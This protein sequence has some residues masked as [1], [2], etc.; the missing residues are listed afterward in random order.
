MGILTRKD[1]SA[2]ITDLE[3]FTLEV[4][5]CPLKATTH[6]IKTLFSEYQE[7]VA[8]KVA[9]AKKHLSDPKQR[10]R[11]ELKKF[12][13]H[14]PAHE[15]ILANIIKDKR[16]SCWVWPG[17]GTHGH[18]TIMGD[19][20]KQTFVH[21]VMYEH[22]NRRKLKLNEVVR[23][24]C[25]NGFCCN[26]RHLI[27]GTQKENTIDTSLRGRGG[28]QRLSYSTAKRVLIR[29]LKGESSRKLAK[30]FG[31]GEAHVR[32]LG[33]R[34]FK[35]LNDDPDVSK[36]PRKFGQLRNSKLTP[37]DVTDIRK[38]LKNRESQ[39]SI[40]KYYGVDVSLISGINTGRA[41]KSNDKPKSDE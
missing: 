6:I 15:R 37:E 26:P 30:E 17:S 25:D 20:K 38:R 41:W 13:H 14:T 27:V 3:V 29:F 16:T 2:L 23:H 39:K 4:P 24:T 35:E 28:N 7:H 40:A 34:T 5:E 12:P 21:R 32:R 8:K 31:I 19:D 36:L 33:I 22:A 9:G 18:G 11:R 1:V 10:V